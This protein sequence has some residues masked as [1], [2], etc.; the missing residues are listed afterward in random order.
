MRTPRRP[1]D[2]PSLS[3]N[4]KFVGKGILGIVVFVA[5]YMLASFTGGFIAGMFGVLFGWTA[6]TVHALTWSLPKLIFLGR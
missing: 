3:E 1:N 6:N 4:I 2:E 5:A